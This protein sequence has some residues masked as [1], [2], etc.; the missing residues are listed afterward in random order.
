MLNDEP[1]LLQVNI[2]QFAMEGHESK[3]SFL[4]GTSTATS[5]TCS[6]MAP[7]PKVESQVL[8]TMEISELLS[9]A[10]LDT[11]GQASG[12]STPQETSIPGPRGTT[13]FL[14]V[15]TAKPV[16][17][18]SQ[19]SPQASIPDN[20][21]LE[22]PTLEDISLP[23]KTLGLGASALPVDVGQLQEEV[24]KALGCLLMT[25]S[26]FDACW[27][28]QVLNFEMAFCQNELVTTEAIKEAKTLCTCT[29]REAEAHH[30][31]LISET[32]TQHATCIKEGKANCASIVA[33][34]ENSCSMAIR[35]AESG[36][37]RQTHSIQQSY[38]KGMQHLEVEALEK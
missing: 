26:S 31:M 12:C 8:M 30:V 1:I 17:T 37:T 24:G 38:A 19:V 13:P 34:A 5:P 4:S 32:E 23:I 11:S 14:L 6:A 22:D 27:W 35:K 25:R 9:W 29:I 20:V 10:A 3:T 36:G 18:S 15:S 2:L 7:T 28:R 33:E 16:D 21:E